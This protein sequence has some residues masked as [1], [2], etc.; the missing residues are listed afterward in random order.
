MNIDDRNLD[1]R[2]REVDFWLDEGLT[3]FAQ[4]EPRT[5]LEGR[6]LAR[7]AEAKHQSER[8]LRWWSALAF[9]AAALVA[10]LLV[11]HGRSQSPHL[12][13]H[14]IATTSAPPQT[15]EHAARADTPEPEH[16]IVDPKHMVRAARNE[17]SASPKL[18]RFP[19]PQPLTE[20]E[21]LLA[22][23]VRQFPHNAE[24]MAQLQTD[25]RQQDEQEMAAPW[26]NANS[27]KFDEQQ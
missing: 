13:E 20:Q 4:A 22:R 10:L 12:A 23:Y 11:W 5:G 19:V 26:P 25:L 15:A 16:S 21:Q 6:V 8:K 3:E 27:G 7:L 17:S 24:M 9:S 2:D 1:R 14:R 18:E